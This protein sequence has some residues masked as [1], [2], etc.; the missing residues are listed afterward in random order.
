MHVAV[1]IW[2]F[3]AHGHIDSAWGPHRGRARVILTNFPPMITAAAP[4]L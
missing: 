2:N 3:N 1:V 4:A